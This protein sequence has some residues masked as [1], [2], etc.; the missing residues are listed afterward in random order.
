MPLKS[1]SSKKNISKNIKE[2]VADNKKTGKAM[3]ANWVKRPMKQIIAISLNL[4]PKE[5]SKK[6]K[7]MDK[8][9]K[10]K[11]VEKKEYKTK[12]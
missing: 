12:K 3:W 4:K 6:D 7:M 11:K 10:E 8:G 1:S 2:L 9:K 5:I